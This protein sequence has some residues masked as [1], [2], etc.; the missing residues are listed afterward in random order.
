MAQAKDLTFGQ[1]VRLD[2]RAKNWTI[3]DFV[4]ELNKVKPRPL[5]PKNAYH[6][7]VV[8]LERGQLSHEIGPEVRAWLAKTLGAKNDL[9]Q[10]LS[11]P[12]VESSTPTSLHQ[13]DDLFTRLSQEG[14]LLCIEYRDMPRATVGAKYS[15]YVGVAGDA[16]LSGLSIA[17]FQPFCIPESPIVHT[18]TVTR[19]VADV[20]DQVRKFYVEV[21]D[22]MSEIEPRRKHWE[23]RIKLFERWDPQRAFLG[24]GIQTRLF[25]AHFPPELERE[26]EVWEWVA[27]EG[28]DVF[29][30]RDR[31]S[32]PHD[33]ILTQFFPITDYFLKDGNQLPATQRVLNKYWADHREDVTV[34]A[35]ADVNWIKQ[36]S[37]VPNSILAPCPWKIFEQK[38]LR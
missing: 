18:K 21:Y 37:A 14:S 36:N 35:D 20:I 13:A 29:V 16:I 4:S 3:A 15:R 32:V 6:A 31:S 27:A 2:R 28:G 8:K 17:M 12:I 9:Y 24:S 25:Y 38:K 30:H 23:G 10:R 33:I 22:Y 7:W 1:Q 5:H 26:A 11:T 34:F 19:Y